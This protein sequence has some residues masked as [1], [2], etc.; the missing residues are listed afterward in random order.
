MTQGLE[1]IALTDKPGGVE[2]DLPDHCSPSC[3]GV[4]SSGTSLTPNDPAYMTGEKGNSITIVD[5]VQSTNTWT[6]I[7]GMLIGKESSRSLV[8]YQHESHTHWFV[9]AHYCIMYSL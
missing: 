7:I 1:K 4:H 3:S 8:T 2:Y 6:L 5:I 9:E